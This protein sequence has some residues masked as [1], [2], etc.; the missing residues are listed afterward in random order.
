MS[1]VRVYNAGLA[2]H[3][4][5]W[6]Q[7]CIIGAPDSILIERCRWLTSVAGLEYKYADILA[8]RL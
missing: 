4:D 3:P 8:L 1:D 7:Q 6:K 5:A 2:M